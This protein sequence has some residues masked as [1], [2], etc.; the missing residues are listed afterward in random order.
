MDLSCSTLFDCSS[1]DD[2]QQAQ[3]DVYYM[4]TKNIKCL[5]YVG[6]GR[7]ICKNFASSNKTKDKSM[8]TYI[9]T[10]RWYLLILNII[11]RKHWEVLHHIFEF[12]LNKFSIHRPETFWYT[13]VIISFPTKRYKYL[14]FFCK[15]FFQTFVKNIQLCRFF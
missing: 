7:Y 10:W 11:N 12:N 6:N 4:V 8:L 14:Q 5:I 15:Y 1:L 2:N 3:W 9:N 13:V